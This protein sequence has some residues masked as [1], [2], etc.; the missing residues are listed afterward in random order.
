MLVLELVLKILKNSKSFSLIF[1]LNFCLAIASLSYLQFF[2]S[3]IN[4]SLDSEAKNLLGADLVISSRFKINDEQIENVKSKLPKIKAFDKGLSTISMIRSEKRARLMEVVQINE[5][6]PFYGGF[7]F[8][9]KTSYPSTRKLPQN[10]EI[11][12]YKEVLDLLNIQKGDKLKIGKKEFLISKVIIEDSL[13]AVSFSGFMPKIYLNEQALKSTE[14]LGFGST[15]RYK[16]NYL[17]EEKLDNKQ[18]EDLEK[19]L[20]EQLEQNLRVLSPNDGRDRLLNVLKF[21]TNFLSLV[22]LI[23]FFLGLVA[24]IYLYS[25]FLRTHEKD[26]SILND[27]GVNKKTISI[28]YLSHL[29]SLVFISSLIVFFIIIISGQFIA[30]IIQKLINFS[31]E[32]NFDYSF[33][34]KALLALVLVCLSI[35]TP[36]ILPLISKTKRSYIKILLSFAP[37]IGFL[38]V[39]AHFVSSS[40]NIG[41]Y[42]AFFIFIII[43][44]LFTFGSLILKKLDFSGHL[45]NLSLSLAFKNITRQRKTSLTLFTAILLCTAFFSLIPQVGSS[46]NSSLNSN[47]EDRPRFFVIDA[48]ENQLEQIKKEVENQGAKLENISAMIR[49]RITK[50]NDIDFSKERL[51][52]TLKNTAVN[53][54]YRND[55]KTSET[56]VEGREFSG[57]YNSNDFSEIVELSVEQRYAKRRNIK[58]GDIIIFDVLGLEIKTKV[59]NIRTVNWLEF[60][61]NFFFV[62]QKGAIDDAPN[63]ILATISNADYNG[64]NLML[65]LNDLFPN[66]TIIDVKNLFETFSKLVN[67][68]SKI[69]DKMSYYSIIVGLLMSFIIIQYQMNL[70]KNNILRLKMIGVDNKTIKNSFL[71]EFTFISLVSSFLGMA[72]GSACSY[73][74]SDLLFQSVWDFRI[75]VLLSYI[76]FIPILTILVVNYFTSKIIRQKE[77][78]LFGE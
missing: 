73:F 71:I 2:K 15:A 13:K 5:N 32:F 49:A 52:N 19:K 29:F 54:T 69:T 22:S 60:T 63:T 39:I 51:D 61:P 6:Y 38:L 7:T 14:L 67:S 20:E 45:E 68:V 24:L 28:A 17:F 55:L 57:V 74:I 30:P 43:F 44:L 75:E 41:L 64:I 1:I 21:L 31:F 77:N 33:F 37:F 36:L 4:S 11:W 3:S 58:L 78:I 26:I 25:G 35:G 34:F 76:F 8:K 48:K 12:V 59:V 18:L 72:F 9:D 27:L 46:L 62:L 42:F 66:L 53:L 70:Q 40:K 23:S 65:K 10:N 50:I 47:L 16:L 56:I